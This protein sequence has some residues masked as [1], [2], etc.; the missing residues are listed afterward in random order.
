V[1]SVR[2][3]VRDYRD[4]WE[5]S[6]PGGRAIL[7][8][9]LVFVARVVGFSF[10]FPLYAKASGY[11]TEQYGLLYSLISIV[12]I[13]ALVPILWL[14]RRGW[15]RRLMMIG[16]ALGL[17]GIT[18]LIVARELPLG[19]WV[20]AMILIGGSS[21]T[22]WTLSDPLLAEATH[23]E[24]R[25][26]AF[27]LKWLFFT[28]GSSV[29]ALLAGVVP[30]LL[31]SFGGVGERNSYWAMLFVLGMLDLAQIR[32]FSGSPVRRMARA[33]GLSWKQRRA[34]FRAIGVALVLFA[35]ADATSA[36]GYNTIRPYISL[37]LTEGHGLSSGAAGLVIGS[38]A[39][40]AAAGALS[41][42]MLAQRI[43]NTRA[44]AILR[45]GGAASI[46]G[47]FLVGDSTALVI[48][49]IFLYYGLVDGTSALYSTEVMGRLPASARDL[50]AGLNNVL[51][52]LV[53]A[54]AVALSGYLQ[55]RPGGGFGL[56]FSVAVVGY[57]VSALWCALVLPRI[58]V[59]ADTPSHGA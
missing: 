58:R 9:S 39:F 13:V 38:T 37:F 54:G 2:Q 32:F 40:V 55:D 3:A 31:K 11:S 17:A 23:P 29:G 10:L 30:E 59:P 7:L 46:A 22:Y 15:D 26:R 19:Y 51:W 42:P 53:S 56:A 36:L 57:I 5:R 4:T 33:P 8:G 6:G 27:A 25:A 18:V 52:S 12:P 45:L 21:A 35:I 47:W 43:G 34:A 49:L 24:I 41:M 28:I 14:A 50:M 44:M 48:A 1:G 16:P 20:P